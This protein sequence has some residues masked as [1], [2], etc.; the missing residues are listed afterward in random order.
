[1]TNPYEAFLINLM[2]GEN[3]ENKN[4]KFKKYFKEFLNNFNKDNVMEAIAL[5][6]YYHIYKSIPKDLY[7]VEDLKNTYGN[8]NEINGYD[9]TYVLGGS[10]FSGI[11]NSYAGYNQTFV[12][13]FFQYKLA[14]TYPH[15]KMAACRNPEKMKKSFITNCKQIMENLYSL[16]LSEEQ[17]TQTEKYRNYVCFNIKHMLTYLSKFDNEFSEVGCELFSNFETNK[18]LK[19]TEVFTSIGKILNQH[20]IKYYHEKEILEKSQPNHL[21]PDIVLNDKRFEHIYDYLE[22][23]CKLDSAVIK[24]I[25]TSH[26]K[27]KIGEQ[28]FG[29]YINGEVIGHQNNKVDIREDNGN[30]ISLKTSY[31]NIWNN[32]LSYLNS[33]NESHSILIDSINEKTPLFKIKGIDWHNTIKSFITGNENIQELAFQKIVMDEFNHKPIDIK[34]WRI[35]VDKVLD[36]IESKQFIFQNNNIIVFHEQEQILKFNIKKRTDKIQIMVC[37]EESLLNHAVENGLGIFIHPVNSQTG[38]KI[39]I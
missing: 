34:V 4:I 5:N 29:S 13:N 1:M 33:S 39:K 18:N 32:H 20:L 3:Q 11:S 23:K 8:Y 26:E 36:L 38:T 31:S 12:N 19:K 25:L 10:N 22:G 37:T 35:N 16:P 17:F 30:N 27:G 24:G 7:S 6:D 28:V 15:I 2:Q 9:F 14:V 21:M